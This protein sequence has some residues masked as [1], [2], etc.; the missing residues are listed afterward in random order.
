MPSKFVA[1][2]GE[3]KQQAIDAEIVEIK[4]AV[5]KANRIHFKP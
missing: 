2:A 1:L 4:K 3:E 5:K